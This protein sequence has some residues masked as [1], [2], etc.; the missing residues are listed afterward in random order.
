MSPITEWRTVDMGTGEITNVRIDPDAAPKDG[1]VLHGRTPGN[2]ER[3]AGYEPP[4]SVVDLFR[5]LTHDTVIDRAGDRMRYGGATEDMRRDLLLRARG[6][7][8]A[9][10]NAAR[11]WAADWFTV[12]IG[13][14]HSHGEW[15]D[16]R[17]AQKY[18]Q[19][20]ESGVHVAAQLARLA[21]NAREVTVA[22]RKLDDAVGRRDKGGRHIAYT[23]GGVKVLIRYG[24]VDKR[25]TGRGRGA[26]TNYRLV[27][28]QQ[29]TE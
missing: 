28:P 16:G 20:P 24:Y 5:I 27:L 26:R 23:Q 15:L 4:R 17:N 6:P 18:R 12:V 19:V 3:W 21:G 1:K 25:V 9:E 2:P 7:L 10:E 13:A 29:C 22:E 14:L 11:G 8:S